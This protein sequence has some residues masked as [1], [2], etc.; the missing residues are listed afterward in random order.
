MSINI[1][2]E[3]VFQVWYLP[4][5]LPISLLTVSWWREAINHAVA[6]VAASSDKVFHVQVSL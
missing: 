6:Q 2:S 3:S 4:L 5:Y 1:V